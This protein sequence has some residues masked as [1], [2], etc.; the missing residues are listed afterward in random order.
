MTSFAELEL[1]KNQLD[2]HAAD[3]RGSLIRAIDKEIC[4]LDLVEADIQIRK[5]HS[6][7]LWDYCIVGKNSWNS[8]SMGHLSDS[9]LKEYR[10][11]SLSDAKSGETTDY[12]TIANVFQWTLDLTI[13]DGQRGGSGEF[14][15]FMFSC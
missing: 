5:Q 14:L 3:I 1:I 15:S 2:K 9:L 11:I 8:R 12:S 13:P 6:G 7:H 4:R 10:E